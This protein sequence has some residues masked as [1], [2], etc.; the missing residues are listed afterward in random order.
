MTNDSYDQLI[1]ARNGV[2]ADFFPPFMAFLWRITDQIIPGPFGMLLLQ[3]VLIWLATFLIALYWFGRKKCTLFSFVPVLI[4]FLPPV[5][6]IS[7]MIWKDVLMWAFLMLA[8]GV[9]GSLEPVSARLR[10]ADYA[11]LAVVAGMLFLAMLVRHNA[12]FA[13]VP[14]MILSI[15][16]STEKL[17]LGRITYPGAIG[18][19]LCIIL[20]FGAT[21]TT[22]FLS[23][24]HTNP[25]G[26]LAIFDIAGIIYRMPDRQEQETYYAQLPARLRGEGSLDRLLQTYNP[27]DVLSMFPSV[28]SA[29]ALRA[30]IR[31]AERDGH[32]SALGCAMDSDPSAPPNNKISTYC[33]ELTNEEKLSLFRLWITSATDFPVA[34]LLH[35]MSAFRHQIH[36]DDQPV[37]D[38]FFP[39]QD[40]FRKI[41]EIYDFRDADLIANLN[42]FQIK[43]KRSLSHP[44]TWMPI[45]RP[46]GY[47]LLSAFIVG[48]CLFSPTE[49]RVQVALIS[50]SGIAHAGG[51]FL[52]AWSTDYRYY[53]YLTYT[54]MLAL[55]LLLRTYLTHT[56]THLTKKRNPP[57][58]C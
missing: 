25:W 44:Y 40:G 48:V 46:W 24:Y 54:S 58:G 36:L 10:W 53:Q 19:L 21:L 16:R 33:F 49:A 9:S 31:K 1:E 7:G 38:A 3:M 6:G 45:Y 17:R 55:F 51:L 20:Q 14:I 2:Y 43:V 22:E 18:L 57:W 28:G 42:W 35:R 39:V 30:G 13:A 26:Y 12:G 5:L 15:A 34:W 27:S 56:H 37:W 4:V 11:K 41:V 32:P 47:L 52:L 23:A 50:S 8:I 29:L